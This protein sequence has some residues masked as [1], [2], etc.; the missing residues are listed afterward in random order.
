MDRR[1]QAVEETRR[2]IVNA[3]VILH[4]QQGILATSWEDIA[5]K[6]DVALATVYR[7][8]PSLEELVPA[9]GEQVTAV[10]KPPTLETACV[11]FSD[12]PARSGR[13]EL[14]VREL[15]EFYDR[16]RTFLDA[17]LQDANQVPALAGWFAAWDRTREEIVREALQPEGAGETDVQKIVALTDFRV[18]LSLSDQ[19]VPMEEAVATVSEMLS[20][21][22]AGPTKA[23]LA[24][25]HD[26]PN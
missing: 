19:K 6:A 11:T 9:C 20:H 17:A 15:F 1:I 25:K 14:L 7:H 5:K 3:T 16:G 13:I 22:L 10:M 4:G 24:D 23:K 26:D 8:F 2:R 12:T 21:L 18:W